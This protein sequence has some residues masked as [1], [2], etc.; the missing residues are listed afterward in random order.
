[1]VV[2]D[3]VVPEAFNGFGYRGRNVNSP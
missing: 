3:E 2:G 1:M